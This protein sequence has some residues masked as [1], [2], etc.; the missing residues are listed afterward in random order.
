MS[1]IKL[2]LRRINLIILFLSLYF[3]IFATGGSYIGEY[4]HQ[5]IT[6]RLNA[7]GANV[8]FK[9]TPDVKKYLDQ[10]IVNH[11]HSSEILIGRSLYYFPMIEEKIIEKDLPAE[12]KY[13]AIVESALKPSARSKVG[14]VGLWQFMRTTARMYGLKIDNVIDERRDIV[15]STEAALDY[16][17]DLHNRFGDWTLALA[18][19]NCGPGNVSKAMNLS[20]GKDY[21]SIRNYLPTETRNYVPKFIAMA[22]LMNYYSDHELNPSVPETLFIETR[23][24]KIFEKISFKQISELSGIDIETIRFYNPKFI[25]EFIPKTETGKLLT[26]P[27]EG[28]YTL[29]KEKGS[30][31]KLIPDAFQDLGHE[32]NVASQF[33]ERRD[34]VHI[35]RL[36]EKDGLLAN[37]KNESELNLVVAH[38][39]PDFNIIE[40]E[41]LFKRKTTQIVKR[42][43]EPARK[44]KLELI[45]RKDINGFVFE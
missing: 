35:Q 22:Y 9:L 36:I 42:S 2:P 4:S 1:K 11:R 39:S 13:L 40:E 25:G 19:Y 24:V 15:K 26:L 6:N 37:F 5:E 32:T 21:W 7:L 18:A 33:F 44:E 27:S 30:V 45:Y 41:K 29:L 16:L 34:I 20:G 38:S 10:Y 17:N 3:S 43:A 8:D 31:Y 12:I 23:K 14:A 28:M